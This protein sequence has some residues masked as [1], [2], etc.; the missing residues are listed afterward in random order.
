[1][2]FEF[3]S[4]LQRRIRALLPPQLQTIGDFHFF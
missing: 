1:M 2:P 3:Y 4:N